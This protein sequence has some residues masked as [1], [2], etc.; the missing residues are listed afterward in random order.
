[1]RF[2]LV[3]G[4]TSSLLLGSYT[5]ASNAAGL[6][7]QLVSHR[8]VYAMNLSKS[9]GDGGLTG[10]R[11]VMSYEFKDQCDS[12][13]VESKIYLRLMY[14]NQSEVENIRSMVTSEAKDGLSF[15]FRL[16]EV[17]NGRITEEI[18][19]V[20][21]LDGLGGIAEFTKPSSQKMILPKGTLFPTA[22]IQ[23]LIEYSLAGGKHLTKLVF[24]G[25][26]LD[27]PY[28]VSAVIGAG[29]GKKN[30]SS[31]L[32]KILS[33]KVNWKMGMAYFPMN[34]RNPTP[35]IELSVEMRSDGIVKLIIQDFGKYAL[36]ARLDQVAFLKD[37][38]C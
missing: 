22:H 26:T 2:S 20:A 35:E 12:W 11:G 27:N 13:T 38:G 9:G 1:M 10:A 24:D 33:D 28:E 23:T 7:K 30:L 25:A 18:K 6:T 36:E 32:T 5:V 21:T 34:D 15:R 16:N 37:S 8:A 29:T 31:K 4:L 14:G 19:G 17:T 3:L